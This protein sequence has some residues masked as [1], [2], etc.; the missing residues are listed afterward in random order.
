MDVDMPDEDED[1]SNETEED[2]TIE[3]I[4]S[5]AE[6]EARRAPSKRNQCLECGAW[7][8]FIHARH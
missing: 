1:E 7:Y 4:H 6:E 5:G 2:E 3:S 8:R